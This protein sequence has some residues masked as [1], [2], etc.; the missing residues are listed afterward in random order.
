MASEKVAE[1]EKVGWV[2]DRWRETE[3]REGGERRDRGE[4]EK[5]DSW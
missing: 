3:I 2:L 1:R 4:R 5:R